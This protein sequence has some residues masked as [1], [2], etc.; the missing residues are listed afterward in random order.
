MREG[1]TTGS[2]AA[3]AALAS[4]LWRRDGECPAKVE[5]VLPAGRVFSPAILQR[6]AYTCGVI[7][8]SGDD[9]DITDG[10]EVRASVDLRDGDGEI[11][12]RAGEGVGTITLPGMKLPPGEAAINP[13]P[14]RMIAQAVRGVYP[15]RAAQVTVSIAGGEALAKKTFNPRL[16]V[17][18]GLSVLGTSGIVRPMS[19]EALTASIALEIS[20]R[21]A[22]DSDRLALVFGNQGEAALQRRFPRLT[23]VQMSNFVGFALDEAVRQGVP[24]LLLAGHPGKLVKVAGGN[25]QTHSQY[26]DG[27]RE[28]VISQLALM[29]APPSLCQRVYACVTT[30]AMIPLIGESGYG[31]VW[32]RMA[33][34]AAQYCEARIRG[35]AKID[36]LFLGEGC[37]ALGQSDGLK[38]ETWA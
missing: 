11:T 38:E 21:C 23:P 8:D 4:C 29:G 10:C 16:G 27:R 20:V 19:E 36:V 25:M 15:A 33:N 24:R 7:K 17:V 37:A 2:C 3:A 31:G 12:F 18:G 34:A 1:F 32:T 22:M 14:R 5:I 28:A 30:S 35:A 9:P 26:G 6:E 13:V